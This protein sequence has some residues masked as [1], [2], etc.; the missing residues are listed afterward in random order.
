MGLPRTQRQHNVVF[1][2]VNRLTK[3]AQF[4]PTTKKVSATPVAD[5]FIQHVVHIHGV[6]ETIVSDRD[7]C[8]IGQFWISL[9]TKL[10]T[11]LKFSGGEHPEIDGQTQQVNHVL[12]EGIY[13]SPGKGLGKLFAFARVCV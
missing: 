5:L 10:V 9:F 1:V 2:V 12:V 6:P 4:I 11:K 8:F 7:T 13:L 3:M